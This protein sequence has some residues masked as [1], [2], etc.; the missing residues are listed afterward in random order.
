[1]SGKKTHDGKVVGT[2]AATVA[3]AAAVCAVSCVL[4]YALP[5]VLLASFSGVIAWLTSAHP[6]IS[7][8]ALLMLIAAWLWTGHRSY[9]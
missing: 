8:G 1:M 4:P 2:T 5:A 7:A 6:L 9:N 3:T